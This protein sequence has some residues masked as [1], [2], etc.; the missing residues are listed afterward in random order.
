M[1]GECHPEELEYEH[2]CHE[3]MVEEDIYLCEQLLQ[4]FDRV[5]YLVDKDRFMEDLCS[6]DGGT[7]EEIG[8]SLCSHNTGA[9]NEKAMSLTRMDQYNGVSWEE[10]SLC[11]LCGA[12]YGD[13]KTLYQ[14]LRREH[15]VPVQEVLIYNK[16][17]L[18]AMAKNMVADDEVRKRM[19]RLLGLPMSEWDV[20]ELI[21]KFGIY[22]NSTRPR[23]YMDKEFPYIPTSMGELRSM[24]ADGER[25][26]CSEF[27][28][29]EALDSLNLSI[30]SE[31]LLMDFIAYSICAGRKVQ[32]RLSDEVFPCD[33]DLIRYRMSHVMNDVVDL[34]SLTGGL[35]LDP[36]TMSEELTIHLIDRD[37]IQIIPHPSRDRRSSSLGDHYQLSPWIAKLLIT[38]FV[39]D[40]M[41]PEKPVEKKRFEGFL[42]EGEVVMKDSRSRVPSV[43]FEHVIL[44]V[45]I[46]GAIMEQMLTK[47]QKDRLMNE[48]GFKQ[49]MEGSK[50][51]VLLFTGPSGTGKTYMA[52]AIANELDRPLHTVDFSSIPGMWL[53]SSERNLISVFRKC[54]KE[55]MVLLLDECDFLLRQR[56]ENSRHG[57]RVR[58]G[59]VNI[60]LR[61]IEAREL[62]I[63]MT[64][65]LASSLDRALKRRISLTVN[66]PR[67]D[68]EMRKK[69]WKLN[70]PTPRCVHKDVDT[71]K[72]AEDHEL[73]GGQIKN[74]MFNAAKKAVKLGRRSILNSDILEMIRRELQKDEDMRYD[75]NKGL[76]EKD[77]DPMYS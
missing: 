69:I 37:I 73:T 36:K 11:R 46:K 44:P 50:S 45:D 71:D 15:L 75:I 22:K 20:M 7:P 33:F 77:R 30:K 66:F 13:K 12:E 53:G 32:V 57:E 59:L 4:V 25:L 1:K 26:R 47:E 28:F 40:L 56:N 24:M 61:E 5:H 43:K 58:D 41:E 10:K 42:E 51:T 67:P 27:Q 68:V 70:I 62:T 60:F 74:V 3:S 64:T 29:K 17:E 55:N 76:G 21:L 16:D 39:K 52:K 63:V 19:Y 31:E 54:E 65:N 72:L 23:G 34:A 6:T 2:A 9:L 18:K 8:T 35:Y 14:H 38:P 49:N 48:W